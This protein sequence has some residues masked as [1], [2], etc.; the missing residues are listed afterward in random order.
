VVR[1]VIL[2][3]SLND[4]LLLNVIVG[5]TVNVIPVGNVVALIV[6]EFITDD[7]IVSVI[8]GLVDFDIDGEGLTLCVFVLNPDVVTVRVGF[9]VNDDFKLLDIVVVVVAVLELVDDGVKLTVFVD[10]LELLAEPVIVAECVFDFDAA[11]LRVPDPVNEGLPELVGLYV[12]VGVG[13]PALDSVTLVVIV[14]VNL[15]VALIVLVSGAVGET[16]L[17][18]EGEPDAVGVL[19]PAMVAVS[20]RDTCNDGVSFIEPVFVVDAVDVLLLDADFVFV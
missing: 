12:F 6:A 19:D 16:L 20:V 17:V 11:E 15:F 9:V 8:E 5:L 13:W 7:V 2:D 14:V 18:V 10:V 1:G 3:D 4:F